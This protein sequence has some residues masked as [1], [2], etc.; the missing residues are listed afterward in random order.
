MYRVLS[1]NGNTKGAVLAFGPC[2]RRS[3]RTSLSSQQHS[4]SAQSPGLAPTEFCARN[5]AK[6]V[7]WVLGWVE[8]RW[9]DVDIYLVCGLVD[10]VIG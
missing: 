10:V 1:V 3:E 4:G 5:S 7:D 6:P 2:R 8:D 9:V